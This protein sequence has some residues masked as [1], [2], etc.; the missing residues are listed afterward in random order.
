MEIPGHMRKRP[1]IWWVSLSKPYRVSNVQDRVS[2]LPADNTS[3][4]I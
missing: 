3:E 1:S 4:P 2:F